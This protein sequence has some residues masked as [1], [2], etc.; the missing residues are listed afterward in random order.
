MKNGNFNNH[1]EK[2]QKLWFMAG[3]VFVLLTGILFTDAAFGG[4][5]VHME[6]R[7]EE[8]DTLHEEIMEKISPLPENAMIHVTAQVVETKEG[9]RIQV[10]DKTITIPSGEPETN[11]EIKKDESVKK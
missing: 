3:I 5:K 11:S 6:K 7:V 2:I 8:L 4:N 10:V 9:N 1:Y